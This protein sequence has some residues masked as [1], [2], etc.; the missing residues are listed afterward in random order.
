M[1]FLRLS[2]LSALLLAAC[3]QAGPL[4]LPDAE[5]APTPAA[6]PAPTAQPTPPPTPLP[7]P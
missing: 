3:G 2:L 5:P 1:T 6:T 4:Y 7:A